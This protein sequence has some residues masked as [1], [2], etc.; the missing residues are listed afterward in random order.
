MDP[1]IRYQFVMTTG[2]AR[3]GLAEVDFCFGRTRSFESQIREAIADMEKARA[4]AIA[5]QQVLQQLPE[6]DSSRRAELTQVFHLIHYTDVQLAD[7]YA[8]FEDAQGNPTPR[9]EKPAT[10]ARLQ[11]GDATA[12]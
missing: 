11:R 2:R 5:K 12:D 6:S 4:L 3:R 10:V 9:E 7:A 1:I 8:R